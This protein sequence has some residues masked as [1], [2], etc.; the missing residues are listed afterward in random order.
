M[1][2]DS[3]TDYEVTELYKAYFGI[4]SPPFYDRKHVGRPLSEL[5]AQF[6]GHP[7]ALMNMESRGQISKDQQKTFD[8]LYVKQIDATKKVFGK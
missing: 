5:I 2:A 4:K 7:E 3:L 6:R 1:S 8:E